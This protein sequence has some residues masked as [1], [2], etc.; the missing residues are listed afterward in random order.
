MADA[1]PLSDAVQQRIEAML[2]VVNL[3]F[4]GPK[5]AVFGHGMAEALAQEVRHVDF[6]TPFETFALAVERVRRS[7]QPV[8]DA[9]AELSR[10]A[11]DPG[12]AGRVPVF[13]AA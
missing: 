6:A 9:V 1:F 11:M 10:C 2:Q 8:G 3:S 4:Q 5:N 7:G 12:D 13:G